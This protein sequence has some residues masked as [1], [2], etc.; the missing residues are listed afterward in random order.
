LELYNEEK[1]RT[2]KERTQYKERLIVGCNNYE[3]EILL[4][5]D[6]Q[7]ALVTLKNTALPIT[8]LSFCMFGTGQTIP[9]SLQT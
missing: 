6:F 8:L 2:V 3:E 7:S 5:M 4:L 9:P 1:A